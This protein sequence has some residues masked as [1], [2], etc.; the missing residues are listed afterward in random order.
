MSKSGANVLLIYQCPDINPTP[1][2]GDTLMSGNIPPFNPSMY[3]SQFYVG[4]DI[5][6]KTGLYPVLGGEGGVRGIKSL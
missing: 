5:N 4:T 1:S 3:N 6:V 2:Q